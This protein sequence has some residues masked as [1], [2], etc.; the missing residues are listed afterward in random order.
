MIS[1][2]CSVDVSALRAYPFIPGSTPGGYHHR[3]RMYQP[4]GL[5][6]VA[7]TPVVF[8]LAKDAFQDAVRAQESRG[9]RRA[10]ALVD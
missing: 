6:S 7:L 1:N 3:Q 8:H 5:S 10:L 9:Y 4:F 2:M